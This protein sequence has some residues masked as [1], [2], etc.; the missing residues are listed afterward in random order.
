MQCSDADDDMNQEPRNAE[1]DP[2]THRILGCAFAVHSHLGSGFLESVY[3]EALAIEFEIGRIPFQRE[4]SISVIY[5]DRPLN[6][7]YRAD[8][9]CYCAVIVELKA[10]SRLETCHEAQVIHYLKATGME[11]SLLLNFGAPRLEYK[12]LVLTK[13][14]RTSATSAEKDELDAV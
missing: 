11:R 5:R 3:Q 7:L 9:L 6:S 1:R 13:H 8:F 12:R 14:L 2:E 10:V 4:A